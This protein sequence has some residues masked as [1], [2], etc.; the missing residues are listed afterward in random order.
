MKK[1]THNKSSHDFFSCTAFTH[2]YHGVTYTVKSH[3]V[4]LLSPVRNSGGHII[5]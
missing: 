1:Y 2:N 3:K 4:D 5:A